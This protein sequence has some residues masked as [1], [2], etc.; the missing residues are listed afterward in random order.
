MDI[1]VLIDKKNPENIKLEIDNFLSK[2]NVSNLKKNDTKIYIGDN[3]KIKEALEKLKQLSKNNEIRKMLDHI[4]N[5]INDTTYICMLDYL[6]KEVTLKIFI[7]EEYIV[8]IHKYK[9]EYGLEKYSLNVGLDRDIS[10]LCEGMPYS[11]IK[12]ICK[13][14][15][16][17][18]KET[19]TLEYCIFNFPFDIFIYYLLT[20][21]Q[22]DNF[23]K[24]FYSLLLGCE[25]IKEIIKEIFESK[26]PTYLW[27]ELEKIKI[28][29]NAITF[30]IDKKI[31][32]EIKERIKE[33]FC[34]LLF[35]IK[36]NIKD[37][38]YREMKQ[39]VLNDKVNKI[40]RIYNFF[41]YKKTYNAFLETKYYNIYY[42][43]NFF[44]A[45][46]NPIQEHKYSIWLKIN[47]KIKREVT[48][49]K[50]VI[51]I[52]YDKEI[53]KYLL[54]TL[55]LVMAHFIAKSK[56]IYPDIKEMQ[57][58]ISFKTG[59]V[60]IELKKESFKENE[61]EAETKFSCVIN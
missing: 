14:F 35:K 47:K 59:T 18:E 6:Y 31:S 17:L 57:I 32:K 50:V 1:K 5:Q 3:N 24:N 4:I 56:V 52:T 19:I 23:I 48:K 30:N 11:E 9:E 44:N 12:E 58:L 13:K 40:I 29:K 41:S 54:L 26:I 36:K 61:C 38:L 49:D 10:P 34:D 33:K 55:L 53:Y 21:N 51:S 60:T 2:D 7:D 28:F 46:T 20:K 15:K 43:Y 16:E 8:S 25:I 42:N 27:L 37:Y 45:I 22:R 39:I